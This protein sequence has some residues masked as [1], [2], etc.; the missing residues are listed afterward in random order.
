[1]I[2]LCNPVPIIADYFKLST[3]ACCGHVRWSRRV[4]ICSQ[5]WLTPEELYC[6][7]EKM[8]KSL[9]MKYFKFLLSKTSSMIKPS[10]WNKKISIAI[11]LLERLIFFNATD[12]RKL[13]LKALTEFSCIIDMCIIF[14]FKN[15]MKVRISFSENLI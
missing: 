2:C 1:M 9:I 4:L 3:F 5:N 10:I 15:E 7:Q 14:A 12:L 6:Y 13:T 8:M 11:Y